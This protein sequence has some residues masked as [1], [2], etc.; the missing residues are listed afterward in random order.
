MGSD[1]TAEQRRRMIAEAAYF[2]AQRRGFEGGDPMEDWLA[3]EAD[4]E[5]MLVSPA[6]DAA[7]LSI[8]QQELDDLMARAREA[9]LEL[10][11]EALR[12]KLQG[13]ASGEYPIGA[14]SRADDDNSRIAWE[15]LAAALRSIAS[16]R[17]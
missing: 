1:V 16:D 14:G 4:V 9:Q 17:R 7:R 3:A 11:A 12:I 10:I 15:A 8:T 5:R 13:E 6:H 2:R